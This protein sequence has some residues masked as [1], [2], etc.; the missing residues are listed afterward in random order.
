MPRQRTCCG[1]GYDRERGDGIGKDIEK[2]QVDPDLTWIQMCVLGT[3]G[4]HYRP[5]IV[6]PL[7]LPRVLPQRLHTLPFPHSHRLQILYVQLKGGTVRGLQTTFE[8][9]N[10]RT[11]MVATTKGQKG[12]QRPFLWAT[13]WRPSEPKQ[14]VRQEKLRP[15]DVQIGL[16]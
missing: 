3:T 5:P 16:R 1:R 7:Y 4:L 2:I 10:P 14:V 13:S 11:D 9:C 15:S 6:P 8:P 12:Q